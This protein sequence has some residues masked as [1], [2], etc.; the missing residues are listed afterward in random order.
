MQEAPAYPDKITILRM[1]AIGDALMLLPAIRLLKKQFPNTQIDWLIDRPIASLFAEVSEVNIVAIDKPR[2]L[3]DYWQFK[4]NWSCK[5]VGQLI[6]FQTSMVSNLVMGL[7]SADHKTGF[8]KPYSREGH[9]LFTNTTY[10]LPS[11]L[12]QV[13]VFHTLAA[14]FSGLNNNVIIAPEDLSLPLDNID[15]L[16][17]ERE[18]KSHLKWIAINPM[19]STQEKTWSESNYIKLIKKLNIE[20]PEYH[21][22]LTGGPSEQE[23]QFSNS[24][25]RQLTRPCLNLV[26]QTS[27]TQLAAVLRSVNLVISPDTGPLHLANAVSTP[28]IGLYA[29]TRPEYIGPYNQLQN[30]IDFYAKTAEQVLHKTVE[31]LPW[32]KKISS[33]DAINSI[34]VDHVLSKVQQ[35][36]L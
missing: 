11:K 3:K 4:K 6:S 20:Y 23:V 36:K 25:Q 30:C 1:S 15:I 21:I 35:Q 33:L 10:D 8:G 9:S 26:G 16:W 28:V 12:H 22:V 24:L 31:Q 2:S 29:V 17:A 27:L 32:Q 7:L 34:S 14:R 19:A 13:E 5:N 18:L